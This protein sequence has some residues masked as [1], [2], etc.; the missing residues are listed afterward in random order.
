MRGVAA[1]MLARD[2]TYHGHLCKH[3]GAIKAALIISKQKPYDVHACKSTA[4]F[5]DSRC[6]Y[7]IYPLIII[8][9]YAC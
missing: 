9:H 2:I 7:Y 4:E 3:W 8:M 5:E 6:T 1:N